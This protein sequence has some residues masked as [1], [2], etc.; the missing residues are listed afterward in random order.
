[1]IC[2]PNGQYCF[3]Y[4][5]DGSLALYE[6]SGTLLWMKK[7][8]T[9]A[10]RVIMTSGGVLEI[11]SSPWDRVWYSSRNP[12]FTGSVLQVDDDG[13]ANIMSPT[14]DRIWTTSNMLNGT[15]NEC[16]I[17]RCAIYSPDTKCKLKYQSDGNVCLY[18]PFG[19]KWCALTNGPAYQA[20]MQS[21]GNFVVYKYAG[22]PAWSSNTGGNPGANLVLENGCKLKIVSASGQV[23]WSRP[24]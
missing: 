15:M 5:N 3:L 8:G 12:F 9:T 11:Y 10:W 4:Q 6:N 18:K 22:S 7:T 2:S 23:L 16:I 19:I 20:C 17:P 1:L 21:N 14:G 24:I 13:S